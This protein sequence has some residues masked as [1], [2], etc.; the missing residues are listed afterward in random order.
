VILHGWL[1]IRTCALSAV[2]LSDTSVG[3]RDIRSDTCLTYYGRKGCP[4]KGL[5]PERPFLDDVVTY[6]Q[7]VQLIAGH[8]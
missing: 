1:K 8:S 3:W 6:L 4:P 7:V 5:N 2:V